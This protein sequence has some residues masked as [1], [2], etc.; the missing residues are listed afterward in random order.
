MTEIG[1]KFKQI[2]LEITKDRER[3]VGINIRNI[4][5]LRENYDCNIYFLTSNLPGGFW[6]FSE[7]AIYKLKQSETKRRF[8]L[9][10]LFA[11]EEGYVI[12]DENIDKFLKELSIDRKGFYKIIGED[13]HSTNAPLFRNRDEFLELLSPYRK[14]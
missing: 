12:K 3:K 5:A 13:L 11:E 8:F 4:V 14:Q 1:E 10:F 7:E 9:A 2:V 6:N